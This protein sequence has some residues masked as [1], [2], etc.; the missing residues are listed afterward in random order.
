MIQVSEL[1]KSFGAI[2]ALSDVT[3]TIRDGSIFG[4][5]GSNGSGKST[6]L[7]LLAGIYQ[8]DSGHITF[9]GNGVFEDVDSKAR[10]FYISDDQYTKRNT[11]MRDMARF[12]SQIYRNYDL[13]YFESLTQQFHLDPNRLLKT[14]SKGMQRQ[15]HIILALA[16]HPQY[17]FCDET[18][19]GL[20]PVKRQA[21][22]RI[23]AEAV[24]EKEMTVLISSH[25]LREIEDICDQIGL[26]HEGKMILQR[27]IN[28][29]THDLHK[30][31]CAFP[32]EKSRDDFSELDV[33]RFER[34][35]R[36]VFM[37]VRGDRVAVLRTV[38]SKNPLYAEALPL[39]LE[40]VFITE[41]EVRGYDVDALIF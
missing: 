41:M 3:T 19:D 30:L 34:R 9:D 16:S 10:F 11:N 26:L 14:F 24:S 29:I 4:L 39:T 6:L 1:N 5:I 31:Q 18:F 38:E 13:A 40:E 28:D 12:Y 37:I 25:N 15:A 33:L 2:Q 8:P 23:F 22:K 36:M 17:L 32:Q 27:D 21:V 7:R 35:G 20:D